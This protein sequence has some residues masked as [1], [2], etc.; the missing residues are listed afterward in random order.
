MI[1]LA[2]AIVGLGLYLL[3]P[4]WL[5]RLDLRTVDARLAVQDAHAA[6]PRVALIAV[7]DATLKQRAGSNGRLPRSDYATILD[8]VR[9]DGPA[10]MALDVI[11]RRRRATRRRI[12]SSSRPSAGPARGWSSPYVD[13][14]FGCGRRRTATRPSARCSSVETQPAAVPHRLRRAAGRPR[15]AA[16]AAR[17]SSSTSAARVSRGHEHADVRVHRRR[18]RP[19][20]RAA[21]AAGGAVRRLTARVGRFRHEQSDRTTW[22]DFARRP[23]AS[24]APRR[25]TCSTAG[26]RRARSAT[27]SSSSA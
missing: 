9:R 11:F 8:R 25:S 19:A 10:V 14:T 12:G 5:Q 16:S 20:R 2:A 18:H 13:G 22:I 7:D 23:D 24:V 3:D 21:R 4:A 27:S 15:T 6:D 17:T 26:L 1:A